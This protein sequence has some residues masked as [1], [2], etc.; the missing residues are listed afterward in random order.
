[1]E[2]GRDVFIAPTAT[3]VGNV[4]LGDECS[5]WFGAVIRG[6]SDQ[7]SIGARTNIQDNAVI[8]I[9]AGVPVDIGEEVIVGHSAIIHGA[10]IASNTLI[11]MRA[12]IMN[13]AKVGRFCIIG[14]HALVT[15]GMEIPDGS[16]VMGVPARV[17]KTVSEEMKSKI[18]RGAKH[19]VEM[20]KRY[21]NG[22][23]ESH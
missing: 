6:D 12:T 10:T 15:E 16:V 7:I 4:I 20:G 17:V 21:L 23:F 1:M 11:G 8:H 22:E 3:V 13:H 5:I 2:K 14:A 9:D 18:L 19:Y